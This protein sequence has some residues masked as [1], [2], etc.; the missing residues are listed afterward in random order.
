MYY[1]KNNS[2]IFSPERNTK[3]FGAHENVSPGPAVALDGPGQKND[4]PRESNSREFVGVCG[5]TLKRRR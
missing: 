1:F 3:I 5:K 2:Q 4:V